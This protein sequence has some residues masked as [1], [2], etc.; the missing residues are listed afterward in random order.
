MKLTYRVHQGSCAGPVLYTYAS[1]QAEV[2]EKFYIS[3]MGY[4][5]DLAL[6]SSCLDKETISATIP[7][8][9]VCLKKVKD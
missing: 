5:D 1:T 3:V 9:V 6:W 4:A 8:I 2:F 7:D